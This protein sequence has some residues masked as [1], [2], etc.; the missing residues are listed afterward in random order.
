MNIIQHSSELRP[1]SR[2]VCVAIGVFDGVHLGHQQVIR[3]TVADAHQQEA[4]AVVVTFDR[5]PNE[6]VAPDRVP[7]LI[8]PIAKRLGVISLLGASTTLLIHFDEAFSRIPAEAFIRQ[9]VADFGHV[10]SLCVGDEFTFGYKRQGNV[11]LL[12]KLGY[13]FGFQVHGLA[14]ISL[15]GEVVSST[16]IREAILK[17]DL[18]AATQM[19]GR[20]YS[21]CGPVIHGDH[22]GRQL[23]FPTANLEV[24]GLAVPPTGVYAVHAEVAGQ[25]YRAVL[26]IGHRPTLRNAAPRL[27]VETHL[28]DFVGDLYG[29][30]V[31]VTFVAKLRDEQRF[32]SIA[33]LRSQIEA[34]ISSARALFG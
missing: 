13:E 31:E 8:Y 21:L 18:D 11:T 14:A 4:V 28:L 9:L 5:H 2:K 25:Q 22:F 12:K 33:A 15:A 29:Q 7:P 30:A 26:N 17:G 34:D 19:L 24:S 23:G 1:G 6:V 16:R 20:P 32:A 27:Q 10:H 3:Q